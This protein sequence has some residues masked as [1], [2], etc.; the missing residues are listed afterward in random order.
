MDIPRSYKKYSEVVTMPVMHIDGIYQYVFADLRVYKDIADLAVKCAQL[1]VE[2]IKLITEL[3]ST[4]G[5]IEV[6]TEL[7]NLLN[8]LMSLAPPTSSSQYNEKFSIIMNRLNNQLRIN[9]SH[10]KWVIETEIYFKRLKTA[11]DNFVFAQ[12]N[13]ATMVLS[14][15]C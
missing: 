12:I 9:V 7:D 1:R 11:V 4:V 6:F 3:R 14:L 10:R 13:Y 15:N 2:V 8:L 5:S